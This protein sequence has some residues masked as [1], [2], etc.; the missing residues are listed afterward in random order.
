MGEKP[1][2]KDVRQISVR[3]NATIVPF[4]SFR[5]NLGLPQL[6]RSEQRAES[7]EEEFSVVESSTGLSPQVSLGL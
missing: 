4:G 1:E 5:W 7:Q 2:T 3:A 6:R